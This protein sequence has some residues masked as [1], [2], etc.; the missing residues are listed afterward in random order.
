M[1]KLKNFM[2]KSFCAMVI[3]FAAGIFSSCAS[4]GKTKEIDLSNS[5]SVEA[6]EGGLMELTR[7]LNWKVILVRAM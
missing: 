2:N 3:C 4:M 1:I 6:E 5:I 7:L